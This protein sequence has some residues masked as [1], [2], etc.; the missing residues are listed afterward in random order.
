MGIESGPLLS[1]VIVSEEEGSFT[2]HN[3]VKED[4]RQY[5]L[6]RPD[7]TPAGTSEASDG[8][9]VQKCDFDRQAGTFH[10]IVSTT[11]GSHV[12]SEITTLTRE[13]GV[14]L[15]MFVEELKIRRS[16]P[17]I[18]GMIQGYVDEILRRVHDDDVRESRVKVSSEIP[19]PGGRGNCVLSGPLDEHCTFDQFFDELTIILQTPPPA[20]IGDLTKKIEVAQ[21][22]DGGFTTTTTIDGEKLKAIGVGDGQDKTET[23]I[24]TVN[25][26]KGELTG[27]NW[28]G[29]GEKVQTD[30]TIVHRDPLRVEFYQVIEKIRRNG[31]LIASIAQRIVD[32][33]LKQA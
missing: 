19:S 14:R 1:S 3:T 24:Y 25:R 6:Y 13:E 10:S 8:I 29:F 23:M 17:L 33:V 27:V 11:V 15:L 28:N 12:R 18:E 2:L 31:P 30:Y 7:V 26:A 21:S 20:S 32:R 16:G 22:E 9:M 4:L 5:M